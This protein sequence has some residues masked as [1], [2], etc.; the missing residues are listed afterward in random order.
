MDATT[1]RWMLVPTLLTLSLTLIALGFAAMS[2][3][4][5]FVIPNWLPL[6]FFIMAGGIIIWL[7]VYLVSG[8]NDDIKLRKKRREIANKL[9][10]FYLSGEDIKRKFKT[11]DFNDDAIAI[12]RKWTESV[13]SYFS[14]NP[15]ELGLA[16]L[17]SLRPRQIDWFVFGQFNPLSQPSDRQDKNTYAYRHISI[18]MEKLADLMEEFLK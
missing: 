12:A 1:K 5:A 16:R 8:R 14:A 7:F 2:T 9:S 15:N 10:E 11:N 3:N 17:I 4:P 13:E 18:E 6:V